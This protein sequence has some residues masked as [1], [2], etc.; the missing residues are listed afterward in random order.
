MG[1][2]VL[3]DMQVKIKGF[4]DGLKVT[5]PS[6]M[7]FNELKPLLE[8]QFDKLRKLAEQ[9]RICVESDQ[10]EPE[11][12]LLDDISDY[13]KS[14]FNT[15]DVTGSIEKSGSGIERVRSRAVSRGWNNRGSDVLMMAGRI[16]SGQKITAKKHLVILGD[17][18]PG[19]ELSAGGD[20]IIMG[21]LCGVAIAGIPDNN[22]AIITALDFRPSQVQIGEYVAAGFPSGKNEKAEYAYVENNTIIVDEYLKANPF[23]NL[24]WPEVL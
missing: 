6:Q 3:M 12:E 15:G 21:R 13:L 2:D 23:G 8:N 22:K 9:A 14:E 10:G 17:V 5:I 18:N 7:G 19:G 1:D 20:I 24:P 16:R 4:G 11:K